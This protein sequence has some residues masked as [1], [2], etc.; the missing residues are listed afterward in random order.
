MGH[1]DVLH[2]GILQA[3]RVS[4]QAA[5]DAASNDSFVPEDVGRGRPHPQRLENARPYEVLPGHSR[6]SGDQLARR[7]IVGVVVDEAAA[8]PGPA[9]SQVAHPTQNLVG[10]ETPDDQ[11]ERVAGAAPAASHT[12]AE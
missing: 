4:F 7:P 10:L 11:H 5:L 8:E 1:G 3:D 12:V 9:A 6:D 2:W